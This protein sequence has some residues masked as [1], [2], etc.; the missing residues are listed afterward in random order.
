MAYYPYELVM[1]DLVEYSQNGFPYSNDGYRFFMVII[2]V[3]TKMVFVEPLKRKTGLDSCIAIEKIL[4]R[5]PDIPKSIVTDRGLEYYD[6]RVQKL[7]TQYGINH[8][9]ITGKHKACVAERVI[10]TIKGRLE[11]YFF[12]NNTKRW[13]SVIDDFVSNYNRTYHR[14]IKMAPAD[15]NENNRAQV[16]QTLFPRAKFN[17]KPRL[18]IGD[19]VRIL[20]EKNLFEKGYSRSWSLEIYIVTQALSEN[21][22]DF[23]KISDLNGNKVPRHKYFW[24]LNLV[25][26]N[27]N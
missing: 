20:K 7:F 23:Y 11:K 12:A 21:T 16:F 26:R 15:V 17:L 18:K 6:H 25:S 27:D 22:V 2:C 10:Q 3:F 14:S 1:S 5:M 19:R 24:E 4:K 13:I 8:Y 9:S